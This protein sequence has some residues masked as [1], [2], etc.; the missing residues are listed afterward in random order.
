MIIYSTMY[1]QSSNFAM[2][3][4]IVNDKA[5]RFY[6]VLV[7]AFQYRPHSQSRI[8]KSAPTYHYTM[9]F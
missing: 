4:L 1:D 2:T 3:L 5:T 8:S 6:L 9:H 7:S